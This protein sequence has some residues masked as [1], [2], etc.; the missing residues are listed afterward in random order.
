MGRS[1][2]RGRATAVLPA[3]HRE[4]R[5]QHPYGLELQWHEQGVESS[6]VERERRHW[7]AP[8]GAVRLTNNTAELQA[9]VEALL[10]LLSQVE[11]ELP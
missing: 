2:L 5:G 4:W 3:R 11:E 7:E 6:P 10:L 1:L 9:I 8:W